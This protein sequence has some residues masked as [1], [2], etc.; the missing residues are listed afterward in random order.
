MSWRFLLHP[1]ASDQLLDLPAGVD[2]RIRKKLREM[3]TNEWRDLLE[4][5]SCVLPRREPIA[6]ILHVD[7]REG[8]YGNTDRLNDRAEDFAG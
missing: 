7:K 8:A 4:R 3:V 2:E 5:L 1:A 6:A